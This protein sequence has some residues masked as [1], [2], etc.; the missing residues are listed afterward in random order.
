[1]QYQNAYNNTQSYYANS[2]YQPYYPT[3]IH[4]NSISNNQLSSHNFGITHP[5]HDRANYL[6]N[7]VSALTKKKD[8]SINETNNL[9]S[10]KESAEFDSDSTE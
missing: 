2:S 5:I 4:Q 10:S 9:D 6:I 3:N 8:D 7:Q 1:M